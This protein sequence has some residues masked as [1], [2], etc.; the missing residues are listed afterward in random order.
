MEPAEI[1]ALGRSVIRDELR[2][3]E[4]VEADLGDGFLA[5]V[6]LLRGS[7]G[8][9]LVTGMGTSG[10]TG[11]RIAHMLACGGTAAHFVHPADALHGGLGAV[12][13]GDAVIALSRGGD[14]DEVNQFCRL[15]QARG[16]SIIAM[17]REMDS[18]L[19]QLSD[20]ILPVRTSPDSD[21]GGLMAGGSSIAAGAIGDA[22]AVVL[23]RLRSYTYE[24]FEHSHPGG[25]VG[26]RAAAPEGSS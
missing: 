21:P 24:D 15:A 1:V 23:M 20:C 18:P 3:L 4:S 22:L 19:A 12:R 6:E 17:T 14:S 10:A 7:S 2:A 26:K 25:S 5:A 13:P 11:R 16:A 8:S 9:V